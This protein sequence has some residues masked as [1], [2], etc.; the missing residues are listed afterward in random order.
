MIRSTLSVTKHV[1]PSRALVAAEHRLGA[2]V[3]AGILARGGNAVDAAVAT[4]F[5]MTVVE[6]FMSSVDISRGEK[7]SDGLSREFKDAQYGIICVTPFN[8]FKPWM[9]F[10]AGALYRLP[11]LAPFLFRVDRLALGHSPLTQ[12]QLTEYSAD[13][14]R[15]K[16]EFFELVQSINDALPEA[17]AVIGFAGEATIAQR[18]Q[19]GPTRRRRPGIAGVRDLLDLPRPAPRAP[20]AYLKVAEG[21]DRACAFCAIPTFRGKQVSRTPDSLEREAQEL[22]AHGV[23]EL[24]LVA[25]DLAWYGRDAGDPGAL[26]PLLRNYSSR[27]SK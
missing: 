23:A 19:L 9:N 22:V 13:A 18:V 1:A 24:V 16:H 4:A 12:F 5:A 21:C 3:G 10:E 2:E 7:W 17:D 11:H 27:A 14:E 8:T 26:V 6:P 15:S 20:W 25:Q